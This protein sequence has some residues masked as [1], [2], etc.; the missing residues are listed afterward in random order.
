MEYRTRHHHEAGTRHGHG[1]RAAIQQHQGLPQGRQPLPADF[2]QRHVELPPR[3]HDA[4]A[5]AGHSSARDGE[6]RP[7]QPRRWHSATDRQDRPGEG[8]RGHRQG[9]RSLR[10]PGAL[11]EP[12]R[13]RP[14][15]PHL[16]RR[17][18]QGPHHQCD[19]CRHLSR[20]G[21]EQRPHPDPDVAGPAYRPA[22]DRLAERRQL[23]NAD[24]GGDRLGAVARLH[25]RRADSQRAPANTT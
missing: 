11:L 22:R 12:A 7:P 20:H 3:R 9:Y 4:W 10:V 18:H 25:R 1:S 5:A 23:R 13:R 8:E 17:R 14:L 6:A 16:W 21:G 2:R 24:C 15:H 19:E